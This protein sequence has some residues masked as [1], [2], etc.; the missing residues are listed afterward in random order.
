MRGKSL[1]HVDHVLGWGPTPQRGGGRR[2]STLSL[3][4]PNYAFVCAAGEYAFEGNAQSLSRNYEPMRRA[5][6]GHR[7]PGVYIPGGHPD[8]S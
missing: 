7:Q 2:K 4:S 6:N 1:P 8:P 3:A 5:V